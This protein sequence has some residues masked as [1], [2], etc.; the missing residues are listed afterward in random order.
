MTDHIASIRGCQRW[1][2]D[3]H[4][5]SNSLLLTGGSDCEF[6]KVMQVEFMQTQGPA[7]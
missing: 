2:F 5:E 7:L 3:R 1:A 4:D 6:V